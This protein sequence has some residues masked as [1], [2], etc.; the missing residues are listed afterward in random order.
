MTLALSGNVT[1][2][3]TVEAPAFTPAGGNYMSTQLVSILCPTEGATIYYTT[4]GSEPNENSTVYTE[5][6]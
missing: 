3:N 4:D 5:P 6:I 1:I 2:S